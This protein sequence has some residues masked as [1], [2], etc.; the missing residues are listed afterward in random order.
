VDSWAE[1]PTLL[2]HLVRTKLIWH[3]PARCSVKFTSGALNLH[4]TSAK[5]PNSQEANE[6][7]CA[8]EIPTAKFHREAQFYIFTSSG[9]MQIA[10]V[11]VGQKN[12][13]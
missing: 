13:D 9:R 11:F 8:R 1:L 7:A 10:E 4:L 3:S 5:K 6:S 2:S 12:S